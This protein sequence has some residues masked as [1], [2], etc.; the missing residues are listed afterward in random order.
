MSQRYMFNIASSVEIIAC[1]HIFWKKEF[2]IYRSL[3]ELFES[4]PIR[5]FHNAIY[6]AYFTCTKEEAR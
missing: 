2:L 4:A 3:L 1:F 5:V 6:H